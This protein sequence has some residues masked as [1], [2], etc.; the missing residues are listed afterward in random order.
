MRQHATVNDVPSNA[1]NV[2]IE[3]LNAN[4]ASAIDLA[5]ATKQAHWN[6]KGPQ[7]IAVHE[8]L[9]G[10]RT[11]LDEHVDTMAERVVQL[12]G[13]AI[14]TTQSVGQATKL[15]AYPTDI[16]KVKDHLTALIERYGAVANA[17]RHAI[18][19]SAEA[20]DATTSDIFTAASRTLDK[21]LWFLEAHLQEAS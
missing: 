14:G 19:E 7:F 8:M 16:Y 3:L 9:D 17:V 11:D 1:K 15:A 10:F 6:L 13:T 5:L 4:L 12:G 21:S 2:A 20:G 18:D